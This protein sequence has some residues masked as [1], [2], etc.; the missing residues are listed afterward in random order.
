MNS[1]KILELPPHIA[2]KI[3]A[4]E[5]VTDPA[6]VVKELVENSMDAGASAIT[7]EIGGGGKSL[8]RVTD[9]GSGIPAEQVR[10]A[11]LRHA[12]S[13]LRDISDLDRISTLGFRGEALTSIAA[14]SRLE[15]YT[16]TAEASAGVVIRIE[17]GA[18]IS[19]KPVG[20]ADGTT[21]IASDIFFNTPARLKFMKSDRVES[22]RVID[23]VSRLSLCR[24]DVR[25]RLINNGAVLFSTQGRGDTAANILTVYGAEIGKTLLPVHAE[26]EDNIS[27]DGYVSA[28]YTGAGSGR[29]KHIFFINERSVHSK[30]IEKALTEAYRETPLI[31][32]VPVAILFLRVPPER[33]DINIH[34]AKSEVRFDDEPALTAFITGAVQSAVRSKAALPTVKSSEKR[35]AA[36]LEGV[37][38]QSAPFVDIKY[39]LSTE[40][41][42]HAAPETNTLMEDAEEIP[43]IEKE[44][45]HK[46]FDVAALI[47]MGRIFSTYIIS[48]D[49]D[50]FY[51]ADQHAAHERVM[52]ERLMRQYLNCEKLCQQLITPLVI[53]LPHAARA[54]APED[55][56][57]MRAF[58]ADLGYEA[59]DFGSNACKIN[60]VPAFMSLSEAEDFLTG[61][62]DGLPAGSS[63]R[64][65]AAAGRVIS[66]A[67]KAA[68]KSGDK[69]GDAE[70]AALFS[71][72]AACENPYACPHGRPVFIRLTKRDIERLFKRR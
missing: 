64:D 35:T 28:P 26:N 27:I 20:T 24:A 33:L 39:L 56:T 52:Y 17:G 49:D 18:V 72:L 42:K 14:V 54:T 15:L 30:L 55:E 50:S 45:V 40:R 67:C 57:A 65:K 34:P 31:G 1:E 62:I 32:A 21:V 58:L 8:I 2:E 47:P 44:R 61:L 25:F 7:V 53:E 43:V 4:G 12:T 9:N 6:S 11:F 16:K 66:A 69:L 59:E 46:P 19:E 29:K 23:A 38:A 63:P 5:V 70:I 41:E 48:R 10:T 22:A 36:P 13:K 37:G 68:V 3:A 60:A 51:F 71:D